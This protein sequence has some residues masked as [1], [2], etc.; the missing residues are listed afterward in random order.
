MIWFSPCQHPLNSAPGRIFSP[1]HCLSQCGGGKRL[2]A[3]TARGRIFRM[4]SEYPFLPIIMVEVKSGWAPPIVV[5]TYQIPPFSTS[6]MIVEDGKNVLSLCLVVVSSILH[7]HPY[8]GKMN[9]FWRAYL[10]RWGWFNHQPVCHHVQ[11]PNLPT[12]FRVLLLLLRQQ[13]HISKVMK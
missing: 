11:I 7:F 8:L 3:T 10:F 9:P 5:V 12:F 4:W 6:T 13:Q 2:L 1:C